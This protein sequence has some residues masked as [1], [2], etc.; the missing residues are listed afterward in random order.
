PRILNDLP[1]YLRG[2]PESDSTRLIVEEGMKSSL[3]CPLVANGKPLGFVF[4]SSIE[5]NAYSIKHV[6][7]FMRLARGLSLTIESARCYEET[8]RANTRLMRLIDDL[9]PPGIHRQLVPGKEELLAE[10]VRDATVL[11]V[12]LV[13]F[14]E[15][16]AQVPPERVVR[17]LSRLFG[18]FDRIVRRYGLCKIGTQGDSY[19]VLG[20]APFR[21][22]NHLETTALLALAMQ[23]VLARVRATERLPVVARMGIHV[24]PVVAGV[25]GQLVHRYDVWGST[26]NMASRLETTAEPGMIHASEAVYERLRQ[27]FVFRE[28][29]WIDLKGFG[30][31]RT[32]WIVGRKR[33]RESVSLS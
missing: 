28:R 29:G 3:T 31:Q 4:F 10:S 9:I 7:R 1:S 33:G 14:S 5:S 21:K 11:F 30:P 16:S 6:E 22:A 12:D 32:Y 19:L 18:K 27:K 8:T 26:V 23:R 17:L 24:G 20:N 2:K 15:W 25:I 13:K